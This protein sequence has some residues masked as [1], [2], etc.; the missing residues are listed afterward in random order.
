[1]TAFLIFIICALCSTFLGIY[2]DLIKQLIEAKKQILNE[3]LKNNTP[4]FEDALSIIKSEGYD[5]IKEINSE[6]DIRL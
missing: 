6:K 5:V 4:S 3:R 2:L 1:M